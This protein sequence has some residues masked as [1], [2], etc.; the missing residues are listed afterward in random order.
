MT[1]WK[2]SARSRWARATL[3]VGL[4]LLVTAWSATATTIHGLGFDA[5]VIA[6]LADSAADAAVSELPIGDTDK[7]ILSSAIRLGLLDVFLPSGSETQ[8]F[9]NGFDDFTPDN[10]GNPLTIA[11]ED[12]N[13]SLGVAA[14]FVGRVLGAPRLEL[15]IATA[16]LSEG[17]VD[18]W[19]FSAEGGGGEPVELL[20]SAYDIT[21]SAVSEFM[22]D[23]NAAVGWL[24]ALPG[25]TGGAPG[26]SGVDL[27]YAEAASPDADP[28]TLSWSTMTLQD[29]GG[30]FW[31]GGAST[32]PG[33]HVIYYFDVALDTSVPTPDGSF[34]DGMLLPDPRNLQW[35]D[36]GALDRLAAAGAGFGDPGDVNVFDPSDP[37]V[38]QR[39]ASIAVRALLGSGDLGLASTFGTPDD[40]TEQLWHASLTESLFFDVPEGDYEVAVD[41]YDGGSLVDYTEFVPIRLQYNPEATMNLAT[42]AATVL[43]NE[44]FTVGAGFALVGSVVTSDGT[45]LTAAD[46]AVVKFE[47]EDGGYVEIVPDDAG[48]FE[49]TLPEGAWLATASADGVVEDS[50]GFDL[51][52]GGDQ[53]ELLF[54]LIGEFGYTPAQHE[55]IEGETELFG[56]AGEVVGGVPPYEYMT[57]GGT[58]AFWLDVDPTTGDLIFADG[59]TEAPGQG[60]YDLN[61]DI[62]DSGEGMVSG[63]FGVQVNAAPDSDFDVWFDGYGFTEGSL[64]VTGVVGEVFGGVEPYAYEVTGGTAAAWLD[65]EPTTG[66]L[67]LAAG[68]SF[69]PAPGL[70]QLDVEVTDSATLP[71]SQPGF[72]AGQVHV[73]VMS[74]EITT[75]GFDTGATAVRQSDLDAG[76]VTVILSVAGDAGALADVTLFAGEHVI[77]QT[78]DAAGNAAF[79]YLSTD[80][81]LDPTTQ[82]PIYGRYAVAY[83]PNGG[84][85]RSTSQYVNIAQT[86]EQAWQGGLWLG[87]GEHSYANV[88]IGAAINAYDEYDPIEDIVA[89]PSPTPDEDTS[90]TLWRDGLA[91]S[92]DIVAMGVDLPLVWSFDVNVPEFDLWLD[93]SF[94]DAAGYY[95]VATLE[96][97][98]S[99]ETWNLHESDSVSVP[100]GAH[101]FTLV[102]E[103]SP[104]QKRG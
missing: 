22:F 54:V 29:L 16:P 14:P 98:D 45:P 19:L 90:I 53:P 44:L 32:T 48:A 13:E 24:G 11:R 81:I 25:G 34:I 38:G 43:D 62:Y 57:T 86:P 93:W 6:D 12:F 91:L 74:P 68:T 88:D 49:V 50:I 8:L 35:V 99:G 77:S 4:L 20:A 69:V 28:S 73:D 89:P 65:V 102:L 95:D 23:A 85:E 39:F 67:M 7:A 26:I 42:A 64:S 80:D 1:P 18:V 21:G 66:E 5:P 40:S 92:R 71:D 78:P 97:V 36:R 46:A 82:E 3:A 87:D 31:I 9:D 2:S 10:Y 56:N 51:F 59:A 41:V 58:A 72:I 37:T 27:V 94:E 52:V 83:T 103:R 75:A 79:L 100:V 101:S 61:V 60:H 55:F 30:G 63:S 104:F 17:E 47:S 76:V 84:P 15:L 33:T 96:N 70:Y